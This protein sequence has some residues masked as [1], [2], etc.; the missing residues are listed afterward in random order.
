MLCKKIHLDL[1]GCKKIELYKNWKELNPSFLKQTKK[2]QIS[3]I[4]LQKKFTYR[5]ENFSAY[6][7]YNC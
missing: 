3:R 1:I 6:P 2:V 5:A 4:F 7:S